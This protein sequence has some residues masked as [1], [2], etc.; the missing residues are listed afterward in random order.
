M[1]DESGR[2][3]ER[4]IV[5]VSEQ[6][7]LHHFVRESATLSIKHF[8]HVHGGLPAGWS[9]LIL[10][11][12]KCALASHSIRHPRDEHGTFCRQNNFI[13]TALAASGL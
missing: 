13:E 1:P 3:Q 11:L 2:F 8:R 5:L 4:K 10:K 7:R 12:R 9:L 6:E